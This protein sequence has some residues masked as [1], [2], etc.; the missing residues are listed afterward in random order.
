[1]TLGE[2]KSQFVGL[3]NNNIVRASTSLQTTFTQMGV[4]RVARRLRIPAMEKAMLVTIGSTYN[5]L[6]IPSDFLQLI[7]LE[8]DTAGEVRHLR[9][10]VPDRV[11]TLA[12]ST[13]TPEQYTRQGKKWFIG[14]APA[15]G[16]QIRI[17]YYSDALFTALTSDADEN[18]IT[19]VAWDAVMYGALCAAGDHYDD[20]RTAKFEARFDQIMTDLDDQ[21]DND[22]LT[23]NAVV[24]PSLIYTDE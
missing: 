6:I 12:L 5:G 3:L 15:A 24:Q 1:M 23:A 9:R 2:I 22:E 17:D 4:T 19:T 7:D 18:L 14:P 21:G 20:K 11:K 8:Y 16:D 10:G 13:G